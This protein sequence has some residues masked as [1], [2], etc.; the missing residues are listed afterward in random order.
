MKILKPALF[1]VLL[2][3]V[4]MPARAASTAPEVQYWP[5]P[6][7][8]NTIELSVVAEEWASSDTAQV[9]VG[10]DANLDAAGMDKLQTDVLASLQQMVASNEWRVTQFYRNQ[11]QSGLEKVHVEAQARLPNTQ[12]NNLR[13]KAEALSKPG[14]KYQLVDVQYTP[15]L[16]DKEAL[17]ER[18]R[19]KLYT[20]VKQELDQIN[21]IYPK[22]NY[23]VHKIYFGKNG[24]VPTTRYK[25]AGSSEAPMMAAAPAPAGDNFS[26][27]GKTVLTAWVVLAA[28]VSE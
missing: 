28:T 4:L 20:R 9:I 18:L 10:V 17:E 14:I 26:V 19:L 27:G 21:K 11:D 3:L 16:S 8:L 25:T 22:Q 6:L 7:V 15:S 12:L 1:V 24:A 13:G 23:Y 2:S 5:H